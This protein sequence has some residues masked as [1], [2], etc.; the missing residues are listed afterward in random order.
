MGAATLHGV[1][2]AGWLIPEAW[3]TPEVFAGTGAL[4]MRELQENLDEATYARLIAHHRAVFMTKANFASIAARG[5]DAVRI[6]VPWNIFG[7]EIPT[8]GGEPCIEYVDRAF[9]WAQEYGLKILLSINTPLSGATSDVYEERRAEMRDR[10]DALVELNGM[11]ASRYKD[12]EALLGIEPMD[13]PL[14]A[15]RRGFSLLSG[16]PVHQLR[17]YYRDAYAAIRSAA[18]EK[19]WVVFADGGKTNSWYAFMASRSYKNVYLG[20]QL[21]HNNDDISHIDLR[22]VNKLVETSSR[23]LSRA[24]R[25]GLPVI[26]TGWSAQLPFPSSSTTPEGRIAL[27]RVYVA[28]QIACFQQSPAWFFQTYKTSLRLAGWDARVALS[29][30]EKDR[31]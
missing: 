15:E 19:P 1:N 12:S 27:E 28:S 26:V 29:S 2:L 5:L 10:R 25:S 20:V 31:L 17:N 11:L 24:Q 6:I 8:I 23:A 9:V 18:G 16:M 13:A 21:F 14:L 22:D 3:I 4:T 7:G 30:F